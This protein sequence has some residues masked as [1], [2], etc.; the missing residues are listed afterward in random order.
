MHSRMAVL[1]GT[2]TGLLALSLLMAAIPGC[3]D[4]SE[5]DGNGAGVSG[6]GIPCMVAAHY[7]MWWEPGEASHWQEGT[8]GTPS[9]GQYSSSSSR[10]IAQHIDWASD[11]G[12][13]VFSIQWS[14]DDDDDRIALYLESHNVHDLM[15]SIFYDCDIR[16]GMRSVI[17]FNDSGVYQTFTDDLKWFLELYGGHSAYFRINTR[18]VIWIYAAGNFRGPWA[19]A[20]QDVRRWA[21]NR[22][23]TE[24]FLIGDMV[25]GN[26]DQDKQERASNFSAV[27]AYTGYHNSDVHGQSLTEYALQMVARY[28]EWRLLL[29]VP[30]FPPVFASYNDTA[31]R[32]GNP[33][34]E[35]Q[36]QE[37]FKAMCY[38]GRQSSDKM[39]GSNMGLVFVASW[40]EW[41]EGT[42][43]EPT[44]GSGNYPREYGFGYLN[45]ISGVMKAP[46]AD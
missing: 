24:P 21:G 25:W 32:D 22:G 5:E 13:D 11:H 26:A 19:E 8:L 30:V 35:S 12:I 23:Y 43:I 29:P 42:S 16:F 45:T 46:S 10:V 28:Y 39:P 27:F 37:D 7:L 38:M 36:S 17:D 40:N 1:R 9:L 31:F 6:I 4:I 41:H 2:L 18:P 33:P 20:L 34:I 15:F 3:V 44:A 14:G